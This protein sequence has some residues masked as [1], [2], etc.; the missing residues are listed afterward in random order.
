MLWG[1]Q[2]KQ[3]ALQVLANLWVTLHKNVVLHMCSTLTLSLVLNLMRQRLLPQSPP[4]MLWGRQSKQE[5]L[6]VLANL[7]VTTKALA[8]G[9]VQGTVTGN[10]LFSVHALGLCISIAIR[11]VTS[12]RTMCGNSATSSS[13]KL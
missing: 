4:A 6:Q 11:L 9:T 3:E 8:T 12:K 10:V 5:A 1:G 2:S 13:I 7:Q